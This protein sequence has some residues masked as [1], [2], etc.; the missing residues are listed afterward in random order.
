MKLNIYG[1]KKNGKKEIVK[2]YEASEYDLMFGTIE[3]LTNQIDM[4]AVGEEITDSMIMQ[5]VGGLMVNNI[6]TI[7]NLLA[8]I[9]DGIT[10]DEI[11]N[12]T[13][14]EVASVLIDVILYTVVELTNS[15]AWGDSKNAKAAKSR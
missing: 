8:D 5:I 6:G 3:D 15:F 14:K 11:R 12:T 7:K 13:V 1:K 2:T 9:F 4:S 10:L